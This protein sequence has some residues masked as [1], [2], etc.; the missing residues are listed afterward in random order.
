MQG[1]YLN[2]LSHLS[3]DVKSVLSAANKFDRG[4]THLYISA[5]DD[6]KVL[7][8]ELDHYKVFLFHTSTCYDELIFLLICSTLDY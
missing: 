8:H 6:H 4:L 2:K 3:K 7:V 5:C 1:P